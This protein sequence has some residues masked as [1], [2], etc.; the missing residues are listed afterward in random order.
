MQ[1]TRKFGLRGLRVGCGRW[2]AAGLLAAAMAGVLGGCGQSSL[3]NLNDEAQFDRQ[4]VGSDKPVL[5]DFYKDGCPTCLLQES[6][7][8]PLAKEYAGRVAFYRFKIREAT[9]VP[10]NKPIMDR[11]NLFWVPTVIL[12][13]N[14]KERERWTFNH[15]A[16]EFRPAL[17]AALAGTPPADNASGSGAQPAAH[18]KLAWPAANQCI[19]G[20]G[21]PIIRPAPGK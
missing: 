10:A 3:V 8:E 19:D 2:L 18:N 12:F 13:V 1:R 11:Y 20:V 17:N 16:G 5:V 4:V 9:M 21:C 6:T 14:G 15:G 7:L